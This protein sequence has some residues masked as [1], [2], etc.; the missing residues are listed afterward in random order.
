MNKKN[1][2]SAHLSQLLIIFILQLKILKM[3]NIMKNKIKIKM[4][5]K[6]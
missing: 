4:F 2:I 3:K 1:L 6:E 5:H